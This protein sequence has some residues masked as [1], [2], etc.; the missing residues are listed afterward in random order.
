MRTGVNRFYCAIVFGLSNFKE[1]NMA[2]AASSEFTI[3]LVKTT[4]CQQG[5]ISIPI[6]ETF[7]KK[8]VRKAIELA[9]TFFNFKT[10][11][12][13]AFVCCAF[14]SRPI[15]SKFTLIKSGNLNTI[16]ELYLPDRPTPRATNVRKDLLKP[17][18]GKVIR[19]LKETIT[20]P[21]TPNV[22]KFFAGVQGDNPSLL[23]AVLLLHSNVFAS[24]KE[25]SIDLKRSRTFSVYSG[26]HLQ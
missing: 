25:S 3:K 22:E 26:D 21:A 17:Q 6:K 24:F 5:K 20:A 23:P 18:V 4:I 15:Y 7:R 9:C 11:V 1:G 10:P 14:T 8:D 12:E 2:A 16:Y 13:K 19:G